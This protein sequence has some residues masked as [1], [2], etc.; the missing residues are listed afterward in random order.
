MNGFSI[1]NGSLTGTEKSL[2]LELA[3]LTL[4]GEHMEA[5]RMNQ[6]LGLSNRKNDVQKVHRSKTISQINSKFMKFTGRN[7]VLIRRDRDPVDKRIFLYYMKKEFA[8]FF[9]EMDTKQ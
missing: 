1:F 4:Q 8:R 3:R 6:L 7:E 9:M 2:M 5:A